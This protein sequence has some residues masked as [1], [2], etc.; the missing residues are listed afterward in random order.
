MT[1]SAEPQPERD[2]SSRAGVE[3]L[4]AEIR[5]FWAGF[6]YSTVLVWIEPG[7]GGREPMWTV[8]SSLRGGL[9]PGSP[10]S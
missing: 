6:G 8:K 3:L 9:P 1:R 5:R 7:R 4:A 2:W 10:A